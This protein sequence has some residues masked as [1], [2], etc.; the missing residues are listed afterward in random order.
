MEVRSLKKKLADNPAASGIILD[1]LL[2]RTKLS[3]TLCLYAD[4]LLTPSRA[5][6]LLC[7]VGK[8]S[9]LRMIYIEKNM[10]KTLVLTLTR[11]WAI[12]KTIPKN[13][14]RFDRLVTLAEFSLSRLINL[15]ELAFTVSVRS[16]SY[17]DRRRSTY[18]DNM[19]IA[20]EAGIAELPENGRDLLS[21]ARYDTGSLQS[22]LEMLKRLSETQY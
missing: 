2:Y 20:N 7:F 12:L 5:T 9:G 19:V 3:R 11:P 18:P 22:C 17:E 1:S 8:S 4:R 15:T 10:I 14:K 16:E 13:Q 6:E 21:G